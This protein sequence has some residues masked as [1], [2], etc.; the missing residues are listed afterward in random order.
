MDKNR[1]RCKCQCCKAGRIVWTQETRFA[2]FAQVLPVIYS[3]FKRY[4]VVLSQLVENRV[5][6][7]MAM[8]EQ[9]ERESVLIV[10]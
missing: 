1:N 3:R 10:V 9:V 7:V 5:I 4:N 6:A 2:Y 8:E